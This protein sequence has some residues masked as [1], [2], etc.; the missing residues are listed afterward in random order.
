[1]SR[2]GASRQLATLMRILSGHSA[3]SVAG[4]VPP[5][6]KWRGVNASA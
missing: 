5:M 6:V 3:A 1:M 4:A 2:D